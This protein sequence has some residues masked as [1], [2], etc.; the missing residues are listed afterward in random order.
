MRTIT[1]EGEGFM[2]VRVSIG[3]RLVYIEQGDGLFCMYRPMA[4]ELGRVLADHAPAIGPEGETP[5]PSNPLPG[6]H[7]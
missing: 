7:P 2:D 5:N 4:A 1:V 3:E 6:D